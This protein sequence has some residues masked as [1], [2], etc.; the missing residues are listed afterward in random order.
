MTFRREL[1]R[2]LTK[3]I[4]R[5]IQVSGLALFPLLNKS[6]SLIKLHGSRIHRGFEQYAT[7]AAVN[8]ISYFI[9]PVSN[10]LNFSANEREI[11]EISEIVETTLTAY[12]E[13]F[14]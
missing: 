13:N 9:K 2:I 3:F 4:A 11:D 1:R 12:N 8:V 14:N 10:S 5:V 7:A 6:Q